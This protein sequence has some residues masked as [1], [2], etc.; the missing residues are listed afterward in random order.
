MDLLIRNGLVLESAHSEPRAAD[1]VIEGVAIT[2]VGD[3]LPA[4]AGARVIDA[5]GHLA[6]PG[7]INAHTHGRENLL[8]GLIDNRPLEPWLLQLA[9]FSDDRTPEDQYVS[10][11]LGAIEM[12]RHGVSAAYELFTHIPIVT[13]EAIAAVLRAYRDVGLR[14]IVAPSLADIPYHRTIPGF[15]ER[16]DPLLLSALDGLFPTRDPAELLAIMQ[17]AVREWRIGTERDLVR[18]GLAPV[19][20]ERCSDAFLGACRDL[21]CSHGLPLHTHLLETRLQAVERYRRDGCSTPT[22]LDRL[23]L[24]GPTTSLAHA[25]WVT[26]DDIDLIA[27][28]GCAVIHNPLSNLKLGSGIMPMRRM[29]DRGVRLAIGTDG[30][31][32]SDHQNL[33]EA[34]RLA[35]Y[36][37]RPLEPDYEAWPRAARILE[38]VWE[39]GAHALGLTGRLGRIAPGYLADIALLDCDSEALT[40]LNNAVNQLVFCENGRAIRTVIVNGRI[41]L[42]GGEPSLV[43]A[44]AIRAKARA[45]AQ[46]LSRRNEQRAGVVARIEPALRESRCAAL[47][48]PAAPGTPP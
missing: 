35:S 7:L 21:A 6:V 41:V 23:G 48:M 12:L 14:A 32:S 31:A 26:A 33:F 34:A 19:I 30:C 10:V 18:L 8:K 25:V 4:P 13:P 29:I 38:C 9:A 20:P 11:A 27:A 44:P 1:I 24:L 45:A 39:G 17:Q 22:A 37:H 43:D 5:S 42:E 47:A 3:R 36:L 2:A 16:L 28:R 40:P 15:A 46:R